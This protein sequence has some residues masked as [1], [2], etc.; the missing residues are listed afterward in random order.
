[1]E[2]STIKILWIDDD[3][4]HLKLQPYIDELKGNQF[5]IIEVNNPDDVNEKLDSNKDIK[6]IILDISMPTGENIDVTES[7]KGMRT[8]LILL[9]NLN[10]NKDF[11]NIKKI[12]FTIV[13]DEQVINYCNDNNVAYL[14]KRDYLTDT[15]AC[16]IK[17]ILSGKNN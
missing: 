8:G 4:G 2:S 15:F 13:E 9:R 1:M 16:E 3:L 7:K 14:K 17:N 12:V 6:G 10:M 5:D 11:K